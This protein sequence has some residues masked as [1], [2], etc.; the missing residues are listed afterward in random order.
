[1]CAI[2]YRENWYHDDETTRPEVRVR[3]CGR[4]SWIGGW[5]EKLRAREGFVDRRVGSK[6]SRLLVHWHK[7]R[8]GNIEKQMPARTEPAPAVHD[9]WTRIT[10]PTRKRVL[11]PEYSSIQRPRYRR[12]VQMG[13]SVVYYP[14]GFNRRSPGQNF[15]FRSVN[16]V[17]ARQR[18]SRTSAS[19][20]AQCRL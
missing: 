8:T 16:N 5:R 20:T 17:F 15:N 6:Y 18:S 4:G 14:M 3:I 11:P 10:V 1:M 9:R 2:V 7:R 13:L 12:F 19:S